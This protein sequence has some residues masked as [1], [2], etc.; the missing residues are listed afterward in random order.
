M[1]PARP[2]SVVLLYQDCSMT[3]AEARRLRTDEGLSIAQIQARLGV[4]KHTLTQWLRGVPAPAWTR[5]PTAKDELRGEALRLRRIRCGGRGLRIVGAG[6]RQV[7]LNGH[8]GR[9]WCN[10][11]HSRLWCV[12]SRFES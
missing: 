12:N 5:R 11:Q 7:N 10:W 3:A 4:T 2:G 9:P 8:N 6:G 1:F